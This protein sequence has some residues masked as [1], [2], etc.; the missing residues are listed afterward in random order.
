MGFRVVA[1]DKRLLH[2]LPLANSSSKS[3]RA[4]VSMRGC[5][6]DRAG[7]TGV[8]TDGADTAGADTAG[9]QPRAIRPR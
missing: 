9:A 3:R 7:R 4:G 8:D 2:T 5:D 1:K 6:G